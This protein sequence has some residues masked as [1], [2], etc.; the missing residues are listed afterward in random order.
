MKTKTILVI[1]LFLAGA[2][3]LW[4]QTPAAA[5]PARQ[6]AIPS[7][8][9]GPDGQI[10]YIVKAGET[11]TQLS[12]LFGVSVEYIRTVNLLDENCTLREGQ[13]LLLGVGGPSSVS[14]PPGP[15][16]TPTATPTPAP[17]ASGTAEVCV[18][19]YDDVNGD[20]LRQTTEIAVAGAAVSLTN[21]DGTFS[22]SMTT[23]I[24]PDATAYQGICFTDVPPGN[25]N[26]SAAVPDG[27]NPTI[28]MATPV[29][30]IPGDT[31]HVDFGA[32]SQ[33]A[34]G[35]QK[36]AKGFSPLLG[37]FGALFLLGGIGLGVYAWR[38]VRK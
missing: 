16:A 27:Y 31:V 34:P 1:V 12:N 14:P 11:C 29:E 35:A 33:T 6:A 10:I 37:I 21:Q 18:L 4:S 24:N 5:S 2:W 20:A 36:T 13:R 19:V 32:Q 9:P 22:Q 23:V 15:S 30:V 17:G 28:N 7:P 8:T 26:V 3:L 38:M 25:Y